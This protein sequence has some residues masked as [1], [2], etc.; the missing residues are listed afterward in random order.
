MRETRRYR[1]SACQALAPSGAIIDIPE[2]KFLVAHTDVVSIAIHGRVFD[3]TPASFA[4]L[5]LDQKAVNED[6]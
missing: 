1:F 4:L 3:I 6:R 2:G 5:Q